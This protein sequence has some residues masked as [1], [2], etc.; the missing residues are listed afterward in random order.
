MLFFGCR[1]Q[2][3]SLVSDVESLSRLLSVNFN[4]II[5]IISIF[6]F[7]GLV[8]IIIIILFIAAVLVVVRIAGLIMNLTLYYLDIKYYDGVLDKVGKAADVETGLG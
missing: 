4:I 3:E 7:L 8:I 2:L 6:I 1:L 5:I